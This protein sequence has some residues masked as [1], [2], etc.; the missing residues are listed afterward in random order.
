MA[1]QR[2]TLSLTRSTSLTTSPA[3][4]LSASY[5][6]TAVGSS[7]GAALC[8]WSPRRTAG[9]GGEGRPCT[10]GGRARR[11]G[12]VAAD[13]NSHGSGAGHSVM[14]AVDKLDTQSGGLMAPL[15]SKNRRW[16][17]IVF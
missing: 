10:A 1:L 3:G 7:F 17:L 15:V 14:E 6:T 8:S 11:S 16:I 9:D 5:S 12:G 13:R 2:A 4:S